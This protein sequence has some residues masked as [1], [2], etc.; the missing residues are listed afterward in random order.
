MP[1]RSELSRERCRQHSADSRR[2]LWCHPQTSSRTR[3]PSAAMTDD[4]RNHPGISGQENALAI[5][6][7][8]PRA[9]PARELSPSAHGAPRSSSHRRPPHTPERDTDL[10]ISHSQ[11]RMHPSP[12]ASRAESPESWRPAQPCDERP[13]ATSVSTSAVFHMADR[14]DAERTEESLSR[15]TSMRSNRRANLSI[16][17]GLTHSPIITQFRPALGDSPGLQPLHV[18]RRGDATPSPIHAGQ[19]SPH[20][21]PPHRST[22]APVDLADSSPRRPPTPKSP[23][24]ESTTPTVVPSRRATSPI[25]IAAQLRLSPT[26]ELRSS[27]DGAL[28]TNKSGAPITVTATTAV[29]T[30]S[31]APGT[32]VGYPPRSSPPLSSHPLSVLRPHGSYLPALSHL[33]HHSGGAAAGGHA[34]SHGPVAVLRPSPSHSPGLSPSPAPPAPALSSLSWVSHAN[35]DLVKLA[36]G[37]LRA[38]H[39]AHR[40][41]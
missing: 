34:H 26:G 23:M 25:S 2:R 7:H 19:Q 38:G 33:T 13:R 4:G 12:P 16:G 3:A 27:D 8:Q 11:P 41:E 32:G 39:S 15:Q 36:F 14:G 28:A 24:E 20:T 31:T 1:F 6:H 40:G 21:T 29:A 10:S 18:G 22:M 9:Q 17:S 35:R 37:K 30:S 5:H